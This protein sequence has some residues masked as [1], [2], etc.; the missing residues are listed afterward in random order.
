MRTDKQYVSIVMDNNDGMIAYVM[1]EEAD[2][3]YVA[4]YLN[5]EQHLCVPQ[6]E[7]DPAD[8]DGSEACPYYVA[9]D[10]SLNGAGSHRV[11]GSIEEWKGSEKF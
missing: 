9:G 5:L 4:D 8:D 6:S 1:E 3:Q 2:A 7:R 11:F 10:G